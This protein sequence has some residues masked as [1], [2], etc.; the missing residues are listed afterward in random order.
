VARQID[1]QFADLTTMLRLPQKQIGLDGGCNFAAARLCFDLM[2]GASVLFYDASI[3]ALH[4][5]GRR[6]QRFKTLVATFYPWLPGTDDAVG[7]EAARL[8]YDWARNPLAHALGVVGPAA[9]GATDPVPIFFASKGALEPDQIAE[10]EEPRI[11]PRWLDP[12]IRHAGGNIYTLFVPSLVWGIHRMLENVF[13]DVT[14]AERA[15]ATA[16]ELLGD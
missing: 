14:Q 4:E 9:T 12:T 8:L 5:R 1:M 13:A 15:D 11:R 3:E 2:A 10:I 6:G 16:R 7:E